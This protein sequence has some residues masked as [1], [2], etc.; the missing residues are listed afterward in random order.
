M[1]RV[2]ASAPG[3]K[4]RNGAAAVWRAFVKREEFQMAK[5][6]CWL[7]GLTGL[8]ALGACV[9]LGYVKDPTPWVEAADW[10]QAETVRVEMTEYRFEPQVLSFREGKP[11]IMELV[12]R[13]REKH[14]FAAP[15]FLRAIAARK[16]EVPEVVEAKAWRFT[17]FELYPGQTLRLFFVAVTPGT[18]P[19][20][21]TIPGHADRGMRAAVKIE[22][23]PP[24]K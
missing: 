12:N 4:T 19:L 18:Y 16:A 1:W 7:V 9:P 14:Y 20:T 5:P 22:K 10:T 17:S 24:K 3:R 11:Y 2:E 23:A 21:C 8:L 15:D 6:R 13:G